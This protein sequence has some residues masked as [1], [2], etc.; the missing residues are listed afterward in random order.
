MHPNPIF[1]LGNELS[2]ARCL[3]IKKT[4]YT[5]LT[6]DFNKMFITMNMF[7]LSLLMKYAWKFPPN[8]LKLCVLTGHIV[9]KHIICE[10]GYIF[11]LCKM[12]KTFYKLM[13]SII[14]EFLTL[15]M[16]ETEYSGFGCQYRS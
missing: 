14:K 12:K 7:T 1:V 6:L 2:P 13:I 15:L 3:A 10:S 9:L 8:S 5:D 11:L 4:N 16:L